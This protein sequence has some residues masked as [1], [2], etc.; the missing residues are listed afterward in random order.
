MA[1]FD[2][3]MHLDMAGGR[4][5]L[6][7]LANAIVLSPSGLSKLFDRMELSGL[8][9]NRSTGLPSHAALY[10]IAA[11]SG[12]NLADITVPRPNVMR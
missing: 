4:M 11:P 1:R 10:A 7:D 9:E 8:V 5:R 12:A 3:L 6:S 2:V